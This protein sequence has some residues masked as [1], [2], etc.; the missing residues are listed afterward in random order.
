MSHRSMKP[1]KREHP[2]YSGFEDV[3]EGLL[4]PEQLAEL[5]YPRVPGGRVQGEVR[6]TGHRYH[7]LYAL[8]ECPPVAYECGDCGAFCEEPCEWLDNRPLCEACR[9]IVELR[10]AQRRNLRNRR[11][12]IDSV[13]KK[14][15]DESLAVLAVR[16]V[17]ELP[18]GVVPGTLKTRAVGAHIEV[19]DHQGRPLI[20]LFTQ[21]VKPTHPDAPADALPAERAAVELRAALA[22]RRLT[23]WDGHDTPVRRLHSAGQDLRVDFG[24]DDAG[25]WGQMRGG[26]S[27]FGVGAWRGDIDPAT[28]EVR[29]AADPVSAEGLLALMRRMAATPLPDITIAL[30]EN[31]FLRRE[32]R[33]VRIAVT[34]RPAAIRRIEAILDATGMLAKD[35]F[36]SQ[37]RPTQPSFDHPDFV[38]VHLPAT[39][40]GSDEEPCAEPLP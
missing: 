26:M 36:A 5:P 32:R 14:L 15:A 10:D 34:G 28:G 7:L 19:I 33:S 23:Y 24:L 21:L 12:Q 2:L 35:G 39:A 4:T 9:Q 16:L 8:A 29:P 1:F 3:P 22:G 20:H 37:R 13:R 11:V 40:F 17:G 31:T 18:A 27:K 6:T 38:T 30:G 25:G